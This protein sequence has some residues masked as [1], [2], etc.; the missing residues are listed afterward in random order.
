MEVF[1][2]PPIEL[3][4]ISTFP[5]PPSHLTPLITSFLSLIIQLPVLYMWFFSGTLWPTFY[6]YQSLSFH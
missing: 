2:H 6:H 4:L 1:P 5:T 3:T